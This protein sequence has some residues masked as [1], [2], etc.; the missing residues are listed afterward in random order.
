[1]PL[2]APPR[3]KDRDL[4]NWLT[5]V[6]YAFCGNEGDIVLVSNTGVGIDTE[7]AV[8][9]GLAKI[10]SYV[11]ILVTEGQTDAY[12]QIKPSGTAW[13]DYFIYLK[14]SAANAAFKIKLW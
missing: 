4:D 11:E 3:F 8:S 2:E 7:F 5:K 1:M 14:C 12:L 13:S 10:P 6:F 9:H